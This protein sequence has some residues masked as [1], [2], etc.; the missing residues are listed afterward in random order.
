MNLLFKM[1]FANLW[2]R[3]SRTVVVVLM[4]GLG[5]SG[6]MFIQ[7]IYDGML[8][9]MKNSM[10]RSGTGHLVIQ[11]KEYKRSKL[12]KDAV[13][14]PEKIAALLDANPEISAWSSKIANEGLAASARYSRGVRIVGIDREKEIAFGQLDKFVID[15]A[16]D[17]GKKGR[18]AV[19]GASLAKK[20]K[21][22]VGK[23]IVLTTQAR[24]KSIQS[25]AF[26][27]TG[28]LRADNPYVDKQVVFIDQHR[29][30]SLFQAPGTVSYF[31]VML[32]DETR[33]DALK[34]QL[35]PEVDGTNTM[36][37]WK[38]YYPILRFSEA[39]MEQFYAI[40]Y[41]IVFA[42]VA[43]GIFDIVL[44]SV[45]ERVRELG[46]M[47]AIG[48][49][50]GKVAALIVLESFII[51]F[52][53]FLA[54]SAIGGAVLAWFATYGMDL[55]FAAKGLE[56]FGIASVIYADFK[57]SYFL[58]AF[59]AVGVATVVAALFPVRILKKKNP[60]EVIRFS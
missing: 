3:K 52:L 2:R 13:D 35:A 57:G 15:G 4:I 50:F 23:K 56:N 1:A 27:V 45:L 32:K 8:S 49:S 44:I 17:F 54:G 31:T 16:F 7:G 38:E 30:E 5:V 11:H 34:E 60:V 20:M 43:V 39:Y 41:L 24:D 37:T 36:Y 40:M 25:A 46:I 22:T 51:G 48:T 10:I 19:I 59:L 47:M 29:A 26:R 21:V 28:L 58:A 42:V 9:G 6:L 14:H 33:A 18:G 12:L 55:S 53:G